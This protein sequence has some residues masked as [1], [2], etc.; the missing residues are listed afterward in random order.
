[1]LLKSNVFSKNI[2]VLHLVN[3]LLIKLNGLIKNGLIKIYLPKDL[4]SLYII[5]YILFSITY[6]LIYYFDLY[7][8]SLSTNIP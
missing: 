8:K 3:N 1:M 6:L 2:S 5:Y 4:N 7:I